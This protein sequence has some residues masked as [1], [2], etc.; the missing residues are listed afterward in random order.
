[1]KENEKRRSTGRIEHILLS[2]VHFLPLD[3]SRDVA[4]TD[5]LRFTSVFLRC[6]EP[7]ESNPCVREKEC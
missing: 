6:E 2:K 3:I 1:M 4:A 5:F 7:H